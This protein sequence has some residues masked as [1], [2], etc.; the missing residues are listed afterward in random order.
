MPPASPSAIKPLTL[1]SPGDALNL[2]E[3][4]RWLVELPA[5]DYP[6]AFELLIAMDTPPDLRELIMD[7]LNTRPDPLRLPS[8]AQLTALPD[9]PFHQDALALLESELGQDY[10]TNSIGWADAI[11]AH[12]NA[13]RH[14]S[15]A[16]SGDGE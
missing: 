9:H 12:L 6:A 7:D 2:E 5:K 13:K 4:E 16:I 15:L 11:T 1:A 3:A 14:P 8:L 10:G